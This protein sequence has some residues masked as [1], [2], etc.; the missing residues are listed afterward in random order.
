MDEGGGKQGLFPYIALVL[1][2]V[3]AAGFLNLLKTALACCRKQRLRSLAEEGNKKF[4]RALELTEKS[5]PCQASLRINIIVIEILS[6]W[7]GIAFFR[8]PLMSFFTALGTGSATAAVLAVFLCLVIIA[9]AEF[10]LGEAI[11]REIALSAPEA[12]TAAFIPLIHILCIPASPLYKI[13]TLFTALISKITS[14]SASRGMTEDELRLALLEGEKSGIVERA[15]RSMV[16]G[17]FYLGDKPV[18]T[19]M[20]HR[21]EIRWLDINAGGDEALKTAESA[22][23]QRN[24]PVADG[25]L[26]K[27]SGAV[28]AEDILKALLPSRGGQKWQGLKA[29]MRLPYFVPETMPAIKAFEAF[30]KADAD[31]LFV[32]DEYGGFSGMLTVRNLIEEIVGQ[33]ST[34]VSGDDEIIKQE[35]GSWLADGSLNIDDAAKALE[36]S[37]LS[38][39]H[40]EYHTLAGF[41]LDLA[42]EIPRTGAHFDYSGYRFTVVDMDGNRID[43]IMIT[44]PEGAAR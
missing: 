6:G 20:T 42:G 25:E 43:K 31:Y 9:A 8:I 5:G 27:V 44:R 23:G 39:D 13:G 22:G 38:S 10:I 26:D 28:S 41:I 30:K 40:G 37:G 15:E 1:G 11:P 14:R 35:D 12:I 36:L 34:N 33:L 3:L 7:A 18:G 19:F 21:S 17:V 32:M 24:F 29:I 2:L 4:R 16:E